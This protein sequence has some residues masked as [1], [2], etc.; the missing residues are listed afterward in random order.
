[1]DTF[2]KKKKEIVNITL[3]TVYDCLVNIA[4]AKGLNSNSDREGN[5]MK[6]IF[7]SK[8]DET[9]YI[10]RFIEKNLKIG[11]AEKTMQAGLSKALFDYAYFGSK[12]APTYNSEQ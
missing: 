3:R 6:L 5:I 2:F 10:I 8:P 11:C 1:M 9:K 7:E 12:K 4:N